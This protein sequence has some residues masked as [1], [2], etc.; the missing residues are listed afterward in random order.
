MLGPPFDFETPGGE[1]TFE[2]SAYGA[3]VAPLLEKAGGRMVF[4][5]SPAQRC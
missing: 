1:S 2:A 3:A 5:G 4:L